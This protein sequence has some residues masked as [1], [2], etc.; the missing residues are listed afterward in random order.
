M[1]E[2][3][4]LLEA[5]R[6]EHDLTFL[7]LSIRITRAT[8]RSRNQDCWRKICTGETLNPQGR[9]ERIL[10]KFLASVKAEKA[11]KAERRKVAV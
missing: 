3:A 9:T 2:K 6:L 11:A 8:G 5:Y 10:D 7:Q 1:T 4:T